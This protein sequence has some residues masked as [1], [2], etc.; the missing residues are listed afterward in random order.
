MKQ[1][2]SNTGIGSG[3]ILSIQLMLFPKNC[4][5]AVRAEQHSR[6]DHVNLKQRI[7]DNVQ[8][9]QSLKNFSLPV[10]TEDCVVDVG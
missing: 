2:D 3:S 6:N 8:R 1:Y 5:D 7:E 9:V 4:L 10:N